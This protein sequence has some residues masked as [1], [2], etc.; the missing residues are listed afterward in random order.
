[1]KQVKIYQA[2]DD[3]LRDKWYTLW[4]KSNSGHFFN[5]PEWFSSYCDT[6]GVH[7]AK[8]VTI[9]E[10]GELLLVFPLILENVFG[11]QAWVSPGGKFVN[12]SSL[13]T[14]RFDKTLAKLLIPP[15]QGFGNVYLCE[16]LEKEAA[17][18]TSLQTDWVQQEASRNP[19]LHLSS[20]TLTN[21][22]PKLLSRIRNTMKK[23][24]K[25]LHFFAYK[26][27]PS[28]LET[29][30]ALDAQSTK[31]KQGKETFCK[32][33]QD[34]FR[35]LLERLPEHMVVD[36]IYYEKTP[37]IYSI[38]VTY[39]KTYEAL[40]TAYNAQYRKIRPGKLL[41]YALMKRLQKARFILFDFG[42]GESVLKREFTKDVRRQYTV[43]YT[44]N[45]VTKVW[46][47]WANNFRAIILHNQL[48]YQTYLIFKKR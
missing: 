42:R 46:W 37:V 27:D 40:L 8:I 39:K 5:T 1:M 48:L 13:L 22:S 30:F 32:K 35:T 6:Y 9:E 47:N 38:G 23:H 20:K 45:P 44:S 18:F 16:L 19:F 12:K 34:F 26:G 41:T 15:L 29:A 33:D 31:A 25:A 3:R 14:K 21:L 36:L 4:K 17:L 2:L 7:K 11:M 24:A 28:A 43:F 10:N